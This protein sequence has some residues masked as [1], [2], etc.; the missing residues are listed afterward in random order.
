M[1]GIFTDLATVYT[2]IGTIIRGSS[3]FR[4]LSSIVI[5]LIGVSYLFLQT[6]PG[7]SPPENMN[8][9]GVTVGMNDE[10]VIWN[11]D[12]SFCDFLFVFIPLS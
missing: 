4:V 2:F 7:I 6:V 12:L 8:P 3:V 11:L 10:D 1:K 5:I 9:E